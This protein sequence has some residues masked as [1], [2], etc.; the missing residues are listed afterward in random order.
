M[1]NCQKKK[2]KKKKKKCKVDMNGH[3]EEILKAKLE[4]QTITQ[5][6]KIQKG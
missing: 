6:Y 4:N 1:L 5:N 3:G 2:K